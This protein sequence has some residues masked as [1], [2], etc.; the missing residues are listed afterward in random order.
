MSQAL[1]LSL[2]E[3]G[4][5]SSRELRFALTT[6]SSNQTVC[7][8]LTPL[9]SQSIDVHALW[10]ASVVTLSQQEVILPL[11]SAHVPLSTLLWLSSFRVLAGL[12]TLLL[13]ISSSAFSLL[14]HLNLCSSAA[15]SINLSACWISV[16]TSSKSLSVLSISK[17]KV[18]ATWRNTLSQDPL[19]FELHLTNVSQ[20]AYTPSVWF[21]LLHSSDA[22]NAPRPDEL[23]GGPLGFHQG[24]QLTSLRFE[25]R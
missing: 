12:S 13:L 23:Q 24:G 3:P 15:A 22:G 11:P 9:S 18:L 1:A 25:P 14:K 10:W 6:V 5:F 21:S 20:R 16:S 4:C 19:P 7:D 8:D 17:T 2:N